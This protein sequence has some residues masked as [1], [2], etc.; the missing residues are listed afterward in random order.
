MKPT[1]ILL[2]GILLMM[3]CASATAG[4][5]SRVMATGTITTIPTDAYNTILESMGGNTTPATV[6]DSRTNLT[7]LLSGLLTVYTDPMGTV[8]LVIIFSVPFVLMWLM[9]SDMVP[10]AIAGIITGAFMLAFLP[11]EYSM[12]ASIFVVL[13][14]LAIVYSLLKERM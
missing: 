10:A 8:A 11:A 4:N 3:F 6:E 14:I 13:A 1:S 7:M 2:I 12:L 9:Q 5:Y